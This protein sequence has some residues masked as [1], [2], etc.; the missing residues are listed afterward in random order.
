M[1]LVLEPADLVML[2]GCSVKPAEVTEILM[3]AKQCEV[4]MSAQN[5]HLRAA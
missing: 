5:N 4:V 1:L 2:E 3:L